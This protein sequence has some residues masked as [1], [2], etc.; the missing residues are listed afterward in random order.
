[1][2]VLINN[3]ATDSPTSSATP[4]LVF[5]KAC[6]EI[7]ASSLPRAMKRAGQGIMLRNSRKQ[8]QEIRH[9]LRLSCGCTMIIGWFYKLL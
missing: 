4:M 3:K 8:R 9:I 5:S 2:K 1:M 6:G 7:V